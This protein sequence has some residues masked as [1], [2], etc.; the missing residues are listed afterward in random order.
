[1]SKSPVVVPRSGAELIVSL[2]VDCALL[3]DACSPPHAAL[4]VDTSATRAETRTR[5]TVNR[6]WRIGS[7]VHPGVWTY[8]TSP[9]SGCA[10]DESA[11]SLRAQSS[12]PCTPVAFVQ[13]SC[14]RVKHLRQAMTKTHTGGCHCGTVRFEVE[15]TLDNLVRCNCSICSKAGWLLAF[16]PEAAFTQE[17]G[18]D[19][20]RDYQFGNKNIHH[21]F[22]T[23]CG[24]RSFGWGL[25]TDGNKMYS[26]NARCLDDVDLSEV[27]TTDYDGKS[28]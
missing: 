10:Y 13:Y 1:M 11:D 28:L 20:L 22:C 6:T 26:I 14:R 17:R 4:L 25:D 21:L 16:A 19:D 8:V 15:L 9:A 7:S 23:R 5:A 12:A 18:H 27:P 2:C 24:V 3:G